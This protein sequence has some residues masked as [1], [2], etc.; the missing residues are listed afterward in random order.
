MNNTTSENRSQ[1]IR[2]PPNIL[3]EWNGYPD[4][5]TYSQVL[6][7]SRQ[8]LLLPTVILQ[9][10]VAGC[11]CVNSD[12]FLIRRWAASDS[13]QMKSFLISESAFV[14]NNGDD[15]LVIVFLAFV[16]QTGLNHRRFL[17]CSDFRMPLILQFTVCFFHG[18]NC[19]I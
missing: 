14:C 18:V 5:S 8:Y 1:A 19:V 7:I 2:K 6:E 3:D 10:K 17:R 13:V 4:I 9:K 15:K 16:M 12:L 11:P